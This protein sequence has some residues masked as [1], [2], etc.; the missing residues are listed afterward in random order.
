MDKLTVG[1]AQMAPVWL[2]RGKILEKVIDYINEAGEKS[3]ELIAFGEALVPGYPFWIEPTGGAR[4]NAKDQKELHALYMKEA[5]QIE[6]GHLDAVC[7]AAK[8]NNVA[9][10]LGIIERAKNRGGHSLYCTMVYIN[11]DG[12]ICSTHRKLMPTYEERLTWSPGDGHGLRVH[13]LGAFTVGGLNC[14]ENW[15]PLPRAA[16]YGMGEDLHV[17]IWPG[18]DHNTH[19]ITRHMAKEGRSYVMSV[20]GLM[21]ASDFPDDTPYLDEI[22]NGAGNKEYFANGAS[23]LSAPNGEWVIEPQIGEEGLYVAE[24]DHAR[25]REERQNFDPAGHYSRPDVTKLVVDR[26]RQSTIEIIED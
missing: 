1:L 7:A 11:K 16:L 2:N 22:L 13:E 25:V 8:K 19:D 3:L 14:W 12:E 9:L 15:M 20:S 21:R 4:F 6:A 24:I 10:Y 18:G 5:V 26:R 23:C 17:A